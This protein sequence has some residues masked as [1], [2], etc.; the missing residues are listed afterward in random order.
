VTTQA[1][2]ATIGNG[3]MSKIFG[4]T[5]TDGVWTNIRDT[6]SDT[7]LGILIP[8]APVNFEQAE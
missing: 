5:V 8:R 4:G 6:L 3:R 1:V 7:N 2:T